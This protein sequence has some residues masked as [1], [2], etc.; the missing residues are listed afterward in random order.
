VT[1][2]R[3][4]RRILIVGLVAATGAPVAAGPPPPPRGGSPG[5][6]LT[7]ADLVIKQL[8]VTEVGCV[9]SGLRFK[10]FVWVAN[11]GSGDAV[12]AG[13]WPGSLVH[14]TRIGGKITFQQSLA[15]PATLKAGASIQG[16]A[17]VQTPPS[18]PPVTFKGVVN[19]DKTYVELNHGNNEATATASQVATCGPPSSAPHN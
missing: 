16:Y 1:I 15:P 3:A 10:L 12:A 17:I 2:L 4:A 7:A 5:S 19:P 11:V 9:P 13:G 8:A 18:T 14:I 6:R